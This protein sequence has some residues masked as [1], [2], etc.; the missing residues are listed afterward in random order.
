MIDTEFAKKFARD[1]ISAWNN[2]DLE[3]ILV[4]YSD[5]FEMSSPNIIR[6]ANE[7]SGKLIGKAA[8]SEYWRKALDL[9]PDLRF[10]LVSIL[11]GIDSITLHYQSVHGRPAAEVFHFGP[12]RKVI[13][14]FAHYELS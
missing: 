13:K 5:D 11:V 2:H 8:V 1:W 7:P 10:E 9:I 12:D 4:H 6:I 3:R 14:A